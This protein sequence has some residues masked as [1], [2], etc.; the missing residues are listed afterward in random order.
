MKLPIFHNGRLPSKTGEFLSG[1]IPD[2][3]VADIIE[4]DLSRLRTRILNGVLVLASVVSVIVYLVN[5]PAF[6]NLAR[7]SQWGWL[8]LY[9]L[10]CLF[11]LLAAF[12]Q[13]IPYLIRTTIFLIILLTFG[14]L[15]IFG[16]GLYGVGSVFLIALPIF[17]GILL[18]STGRVNALILVV[19]AML[20]IGL[21][22]DSQ[23]LQSTITGGIV[24]PGLSAQPGLAFGHPWLIASSIFALLTITVTLSVNSLVREMEGGLRAR[25]SMLQELEGQRLH[26]ENQMQQN[27]RDLER[28]L[29]QIRTAAE[30]AGTISRGGA[31]VPLYKLLPQVCGLILDHFD[32]YYVGIFL[33]DKGGRRLTDGEMG[34]LTGPKPREYARLVAGTGKAGER[35]LSEG[36]KQEVGG[37]TMVG[38]CTA[39]RQARI[40][41]DVGQ[42]A[43]RFQNPYLPETRSE[44]ALPIYS[45]EETL[46]ALTIQSREEAAFDKD[47]V[48]VMQSIADNLASAI[49]NARLFA[50]TQFSLEEIKTLHQQYLESAWTGTLQVQGAHQYT[51][52]SPEKAARSGEGSL[53]DMAVA[54]TPDQTGQLQSTPGLD[55]LRTIRLPLKLRDQAIGSLTLEA[56]PRSEEGVGTSTGKQAAD[57][58]P[59]EKAF[60]EAVMDQTALALENARLLDDTRRMVEQERLTAGIAGKVWASSSVDRILRTALQELSASLGVS[61]GTIRLEVK[62]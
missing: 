5:L 21:L 58:T 36:H 25:Q 10:M 6:V 15:T 49:V 32:L 12:I 9:S 41:L 7:E 42:E 34:M 55:N 27:T 57:W 11:L 8:I 53:I 33:I 20:F 26:L 24:L 38:W 44:L 31:I 46:G 19:A 37:E 60:I 52:Y 3:H 47:D 1:F 40:A 56:E 23:V 17:A 61:E 28:R 43:V 62:E 4:K 18:G 30:I 35:M 2:A 13:R 39:N 51:Y 29:V 16:S 59:E 48:V 22:M 45:Q 50:E 14:L 54:P